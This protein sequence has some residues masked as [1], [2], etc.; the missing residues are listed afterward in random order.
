MVELGGHR[1]LLLG[2]QELQRRKASEPTLPGASAFW[3]S[4]E[5]QLKFREDIF[6]LFLGGRAVQEDESSVW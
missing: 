6:L 1:S 5:L 4:L 2:A 3:W